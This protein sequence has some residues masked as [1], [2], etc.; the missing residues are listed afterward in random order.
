M[1]STRHDDGI[2]CVMACSP[3]V[4]YKHTH[5]RQNVYNFELIVN[6]RAMIAKASPN[7][8][9]LAQTDISVDF[10]RICWCFFCRHHLRSPVRLC[11]FFHRHVLRVI[12]SSHCLCCAHICYWFWFIALFCMTFFFSLQ[13]QDV[14]MWSKFQESVC[15]AHCQPLTQTVAVTICTL[16]MEQAS[17]VFDKSRDETQGD[18]ENNDNM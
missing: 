3:S 5:A 9:P 1:K 14:C 10:Y 13:V 17:Y 7:S 12:W 11:V 16:T 2:I 8:F 18:S 4:T 6:N 15:L